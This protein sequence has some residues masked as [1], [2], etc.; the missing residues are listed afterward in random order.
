MDY[1]VP[2]YTIKKQGCY[3]Y[4][5]EDNFLERGPYLTKWGARLGIKR[6]IK[7]DRQPIIIERYNEKGQLI[8]E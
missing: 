3:Y 4:V 1:Q 6:R 5:Y 7:E 2:T 8:N